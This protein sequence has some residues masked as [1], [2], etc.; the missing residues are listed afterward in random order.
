MFQN[1]APGLTG[2]LNYQRLAKPEIQQIC[3]S[4]LR[5]ILSRAK[6]TENTNPYPDNYQEIN[7]EL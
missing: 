7:L 3:I 2:L 5:Y 6:M 4:V 1:D